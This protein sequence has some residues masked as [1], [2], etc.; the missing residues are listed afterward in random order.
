MCAR[1][2]VE[3]VDASQTWALPIGN[4]STDRDYEAIKQNKMKSLRCGKQH[5][6]GERV[7]AAGVRQV[8]SDS[9]TASFQLRNL[10]T[11]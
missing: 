3:R 6:I 9:D 5:G 8:H 2:V 1:L 7:R 11:L 4:Q 10:G